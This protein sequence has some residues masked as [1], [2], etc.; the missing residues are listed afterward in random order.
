MKQLF[1]GEI[2]MNDSRPAARAPQTQNRTRRRNRRRRRQE[3]RIKLFLL[4][5]QVVLVLIAALIGYFLGLHVGKSN[6]E[7]KQPVQQ[8]Q[9]IQQ[10]QPPAA[11]DPLVGDPA[12]P[13]DTTAPQI[14]G[15]NQLSVFMG[16]T[17]AYRSGVLVTDDTDP[18]PRLTVDSFQVNLSAPGVYPLYYTATDSSGNS[19]TVETTVTVSEAPDT[20]VDEAVIK[21]T[22]DKLLEEILTVNM[23]KK[24]QIN[25]IYDYIETHC[26]Y[27]ADFDKSDY[28]QAA[29]L[30]MTDHRGDCFGFYALS[31]LLFERLGIDNL[32]VTRLKNEVRTTSHYW[33]M[34][35]L[36]GGET[37]YHFDST[38]HLTYP[39]RT[40]LITDADL[41][42]FNE[43]M[44]NYYYF[45]HASFPRTPEGNTLSL[46]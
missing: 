28:M 7:P 10:T 42:A 44:P 3:R 31:R 45:D 38:P 32:S 21:E 40:C 27:I 20:Y 34:V 8:D 22:A 14:M 11:S 36:D 13:G 12:E 41:E 24:E 26:Y 46:G 9:T 43:L 2:A 4:T 6:A 23:T 16:S 25:A 29:Y 18:A 17:I 19:V 15:V 39:T 35:S 33:N 1:E 30:M 5:H 37:W